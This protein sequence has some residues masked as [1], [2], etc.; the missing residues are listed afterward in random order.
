MPRNEA[1]ITRII[2][3]VQPTIC[4][5]WGR[6]DSPTIEGRILKD[7]F[8]ELVALARGEEVRSAFDTLPDDFE[9]PH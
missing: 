6:R 1:E 9:A 7:D 3:A 4:E 8:W 5:T 2:A